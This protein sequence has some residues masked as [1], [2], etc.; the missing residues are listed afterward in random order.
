MQRGQQRLRQVQE[1]MPVEALEQLADSIEETAAE[2]KDAQDALARDAG[3]DMA[4]AS[5]MD[6]EWA[7][8]QEEVALEQREQEQRRRDGAASGP[9]AG[10][11]PLAPAEPNPQ[12]RRRLLG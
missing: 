5:D 9:A 7:R 6:G 10:R 4:D 3:L 2:L 12:G 8:L 1:Q 11:R